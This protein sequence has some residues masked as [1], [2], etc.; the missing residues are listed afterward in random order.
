MWSYQGNEYK[1]NLPKV[2]TKAHL[3]GWAF[4]I[5]VPLVG[6]ESVKL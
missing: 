2:Q 1:I 6:A 4:F 3:N 5:G